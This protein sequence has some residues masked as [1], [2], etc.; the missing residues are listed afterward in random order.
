MGKVRTALTAGLFVFACGGSQKSKPGGNPVKAEATNK[1]YAPLTIKDDAKNANQAVILGTDDKNGST[2]I[3]LPT[4]NAKSM[5]D[6]MFVRMGGGVPATGGFTPVTL[7]TAPN[8]D[9]SVQVGIFEDT[10]GGTGSQWRAGVW[11][12][13]FVAATTLG[14]D[15]TDFQFSASSKGSI[16]GA[17]ASGLMAGGFLAAMTGQSVNDKVTMTGIINPDGTIG[18]VGGI[19]EK[20]KGSIEKGKKKLGFPI[21]MRYARSEATGE[22]VDLVQLAKDAGAEAVEI[23]NVHEAYKLLTN[24]DLPEAVPVAEADMALDDDTTKQM[25]IKYAG[26]KERLATEWKTIIELSSAGR[27]P[28]SLI[29]TANY[30]KERAAQAEKLHQQGLIAQAYTKMLEAWVYAASA[31]DTYE[32]LEKIQQG[33]VDAALQQIKGLENL[34]Q[35]TSDI[36][37]KIGAIRPTTLG[38]HLLMISG[39]QEALRAWGFRVFARDQVQ[40]SERFIASLQ[41]VDRAQLGAP[42]IADHIVEEVLPAVLLIGRTVAASVHAGEA[43]D[44][45]VEKTVNYMCSIPNVKRMSTSFASASTAGMNYFDTLLLFPLAQSAGIPE[46]Q[47]RNRIAQR[48]PNYLVAY[49]TSHLQTWDGLPQELKKEWGEASL[50]WSLLSLAGNELAYYDSASLVA[51]YYSLGVHTNYLGKADKV[52]HD[53]AFINML[54]SAERSARASARAARIATGGIPVQAKLAYQIAAVQ[55]EGDVTEK[56]EALASFWQS[57]AYSQTAVALARN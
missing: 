55:R 49:M 14:K 44:F 54:A 48:E 40:S 24:K 5:V 31:T 19:P 47:A 42:A 46:S 4:G 13:A 3:K 2:V 39:F 1:A 23:A 32:I 36:L 21:G 29:G 15:L 37:K 25:D 10:S 45:E 12:S 30:A 34:D 16:D 9:G 41:T 57:S 8:T 22:M 35:M 56:L 7:T 50:P 28:T 18:P 38:G 33:Q 20:F 51:K 27:L 11:V 43:L 53:K 52:E 17:S 26:W 6:A